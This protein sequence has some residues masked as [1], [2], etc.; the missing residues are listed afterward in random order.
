MNDFYIYL[1]EI[2]FSEKQLE[3]WMKYMDKY[4]YID[5]PSDI[6]YKKPSK[7]QGI[8]LF[9]SIN[10]YKDDIIG[11]AVIK[12]KRTPL[13]RFINHSKNPNVFFKKIKENIIG[14]ALKDIKKNKELLVNY[15]HENLQHM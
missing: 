10:I 14:F 11:K 2:N 3:D 12:D 15:R 7:I 13:A 4:Y 8:G 5:I 9:A 1:K 6:Y